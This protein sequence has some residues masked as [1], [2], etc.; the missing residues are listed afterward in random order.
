MTACYALLL[1]E[2]K[3]KK[4]FITILKE[5]GFEVVEYTHWKST[6]DWNN[7]EIKYKDKHG[8]EYLWDFEVNIWD[9]NEESITNKVGVLKYFRECV[10]ANCA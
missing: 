8:D 9:K 6:F 5:L 10:M 2:V 4:K 7:Y 1:R 3:M